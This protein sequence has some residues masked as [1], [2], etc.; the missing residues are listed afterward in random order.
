MS[1]EIRE[2]SAA[3]SC[4]LAAIHAEA[5]AKP[6]PEASLRR[7]L[8]QP[9]V[10]SLLASEGD[11]PCGFL[12]CQAAAGEGEILT[13]AVSPAFRRRRIALSLIE[14]LKAR[15]RIWPAE[16]LLLE[17]AE[18]NAAALSLYNRCGFSILARRRGYYRR[19][20]GSRADAI[21]MSCDL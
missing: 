5:F 12:L 9:S 19:D 18:D 4:V 6:W 20:D 10:L 16:R 8:I 13:L 11:V 17:V 7:L 2:V 3:F 14:A 15:A 21:V 1:A